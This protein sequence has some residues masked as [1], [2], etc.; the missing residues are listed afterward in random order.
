[1]DLSFALRNRRAFA[2]ST[3]DLHALLSAA[4]ARQALS[5]A[6]RAHWQRALSHD[7]LSDP[8][9][10]LFCGVDNPFGALPA[11]FADLGE[12]AVNCRQSS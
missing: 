12:I 11:R 6:A 9:V 3:P 4:A 5:P 10:A 8:R 7:G 1:M 2:G